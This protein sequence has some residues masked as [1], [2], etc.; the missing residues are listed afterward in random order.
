MNYMT[1]ANK[2]KIAEPTLAQMNNNIQFQQ[3]ADLIK[4]AM[5]LKDQIPDIM[6]FPVTLPAFMRIE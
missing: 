4:A 6:D 5:S 2:P 1:N 3:Y